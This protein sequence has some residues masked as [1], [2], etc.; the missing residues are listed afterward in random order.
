MMWVTLSTGTFHILVVDNAVIV[1]RTGPPEVSILLGS[2]CTIHSL[3]KSN[4]LVIMLVWCVAHSSI[5]LQ[6]FS[7]RITLLWK[8]K[9]CSPSIARS[10]HSTRIFFCEQQLVSSDAGR[11]LRLVATPHISFPSYCWLGVH[12]HRSVLLVEKWGRPSA[13]VLEEGYPGMFSFMHSVLPCCGIH[14]YGTTD[15]HGAMWWWYEKHWWLLLK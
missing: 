7:T 10:F 4:C 1:C 5:I 9:K 15:N 2:L 11:S 12:N 6:S 14:R 13:A 8:S 3:R